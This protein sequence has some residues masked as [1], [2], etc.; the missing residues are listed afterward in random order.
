MSSKERVKAALRH[1]EPDRVPTGEFAIDYKIIEQVLGHE[2]Y[3]RAKAKEIMALWE[4][5]RDEVV[6]SQKKD[7]VEFV[8]QTG[9]DAVCV[10]P[11]PPRNAVIL[12][13]KR[14]DE[15]TWEDEC[16][17]ILRYSELTEDIMLLQR[18]EHPE[19]RPPQPP[20]DGS[21]WE[22]WD[23][24]VQELGETHFIFARGVGGVPTVSYFSALGIEQR[25]LDLADRPEEVAAQKMRAA[26]RTGELVRLALARG[27]DAVFF[28][29]DYGYNSGPFMSPQC[30]RQ[31]YFPA[32]KRLC[33][34]THTAGAPVLFH[35]CGNNALI[36]DQMVEAGIDCYQSIQMYEDIAEYKR[37]YGDRLALWGGV[38]M[39]TLA[40]GT[41]EAVRWEARYALRHC[42]P[43]GGLILGSSHSL[44]IGTKYENYMAMLEVVHQEGWY[45]A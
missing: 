42:A 27:A 41:P 29:E 20:P 4:G 8:R 28:G 5:R 1:E 16:G 2:T 10:N 18:G 7:L 26:E 38:D 6:E 9:I 44:N 3:Y 30:F 14:L 36:L 39:H 23:Y 33:E 17:N 24:V 37:L 40:V 43:G 34:E 32:L 45:R 31:V 25:L 35:S 13:P 15:R 21:E 19:R 11:V 12:K 22:L